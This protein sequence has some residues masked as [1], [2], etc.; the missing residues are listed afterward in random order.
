MASATQP[1]KSEFRKAYFLNKFVLITPSRA[2]RPRD[3]VEQSV[4]KSRESCVFCP[5]HVEK[6]LI[7]KTYGRQKKSWKMAV[8]KNKFP[9]VSLDNKRAYGE[10]EVL[11]ETPEHGKKFSELE[12][13]DLELYFNIMAERLKVLSKNK[14]IEYILQ[15][16]NHGSKAGA[17]IKHEHSQIFATDILPPDIFEELQLAENYK[18]EKKSCPYCDLLKKELKSPRK[19][20]EDARVGAFAPYAPEYHY[21]VWLFPKNHKDNVSLLDTKEIRS[22]AVC[23]KFVLTKLDRMNMAY[24]FFMHQIISEKDQHFY[25][26]IQPRDLNVWAGVELGSGLII[27]SVAPEEAARYYRKK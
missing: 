15:F 18:I 2:A 13:G 22:L 4:E 25:L 11:I 20:W 9:S 14:K 5:E 23:L 8:I 21:E 10:Q 27:N 24:N 1:F 19:I 3:I 16:K 12:V 7:I 17:S 6:N 26:K